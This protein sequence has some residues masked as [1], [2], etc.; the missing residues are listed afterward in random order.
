MPNLLGSKVASMIVPFS[1]DDKYATHDEQY[2]KGGYRTVETL[3]ERNAIPYQRRV[4]GMLVNVLDEG[5]YKL[6]INPNTDTT[7]DSDWIP[8][9]NVP[10][11]STGAADGSQVKLTETNYVVTDCD[12]VGAYVYN[13]YLT[14][15]TDHAHLRWT[16]VVGSKIPSIQFLASG[17]DTKT[18]SSV[19][20]EDKNTFTIYTNTTH[21][22][23]FETFDGG[24]TWLAKCRKFSSYAKNGNENFEVITRKTLNDSLVW[25]DLSEDGSKT[26][27]KYTFNTITQSYY[28]YLKE[29]EALSN[30][31]FYVVEETGTLYK[32]DIKLSKNYIVV[33]DASDAPVDE[34]GNVVAEKDVFYISNNGVVAAY[35]P[36]TGNVDVYQW[37]IFSQGDT[38]DVSDDVIVQ[39]YAT[40]N[41]VSGVA[42]QKF[43]DGDTNKVYDGSFEIKQETDASGITKKKAILT[44]KKIGGTHNV[45]LDLSELINAED[46]GDVQTYYSKPIVPNDLYYITTYQQALYPHNMFE[47]PE[48]FEKCKVVLIGADDEGD[49]THQYLNDSY[50][51]YM[52]NETLQNTLATTDEDGNE[53]TKDVIFHTAYDDSAAGTEATI[54]FI[55]DTVTASKNEDGSNLIE[56]FVSKIG[57]NEYQIK[58]TPVGTKGNGESSMYWSFANAVGMSNTLTYAPESYVSRTITRYEK[59]SSSL[60]EFINPFLKLSTDEDRENHPEWCFTNTGSAN[61]TSYAEDQDDS[62]LHYIFDYAWYLEAHEIETPNVVLIA[63]GNVQDPDIEKE[64]LALEIMIRQIKAANPNCMIGI[65]TPIAPAKSYANDD[66]WEKKIAP[67]IEREI[68]AVKRIQM[69]YKLIYLVPMYLYVDRNFN[70]EVKSSENASTFSD[71]TKSVTAD[72]CVLNE[73][74]RSE[75]AAC[76]TAWMV[77]AIP[78]VV[79]DNTDDPEPTPDPDTNTGDTTD[80]ETKSDDVTSAEADVMDTVDDVIDDPDAVEAADARVANNNS[81]LAKIVTKSSK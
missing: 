63:M 3:S 40:K 2:G 65:V 26:G 55:G 1:T 25:K 19:Y 54:Q 58:L 67:F 39:G 38:V 9:S 23:D 15:E 76:L 42:V 81:I 64:L 60:T 35:L 21:V 37:V 11:I 12:K 41:P 59:P 45:E 24:T 74:G 47:D 27:K 73:R 30:S 57:E 7:T 5:V 61:E 34:N 29:N 33:D 32:G 43:V 48:A 75:Y 70:F 80:D 69:D 44:L 8:F 66:L 16:L 52:Q 50:T 14:T 6:N 4:V 56:K 13:A 31:A 51:V 77:N 53:F 68:A 79:N 36:S 72:T 17:N 49:V 71:V 20:Y 62:K 10:V 28:D 18:N 46:N 78:N 22:F